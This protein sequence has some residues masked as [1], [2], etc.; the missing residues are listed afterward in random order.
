MRGWQCRTYSDSFLG[1]GCKQCLGCKLWLS[2]HQGASQDRCCGR[3]AISWA[4]NLSSQCW[5]LLTL[6]TEIAFVRCA[7]RETTVT[8]SLLFHNSSCLYNA[9]IASSYKAGQILSQ[10]HLNALMTFSTACEITFRVLSLAGESYVNW[11]LP[12]SFKFLV[13]FRFPWIITNRLSGIYNL[14][15]VLLC[16]LYMNFLNYHFLKSFGALLPG[17]WDLSSPTRD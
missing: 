5:L 2:L 15:N 1:A 3:K 7:S 9:I 11:P 16:T 10:L 8:E 13:W 14:L 17:M 6:E 4:E 12:P